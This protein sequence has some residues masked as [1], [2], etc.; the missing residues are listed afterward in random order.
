M[1]GATMARPAA[2]PA[3][4]TTVRQDLREQGAAAHE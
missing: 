4:L 1:D 3:G 2:V